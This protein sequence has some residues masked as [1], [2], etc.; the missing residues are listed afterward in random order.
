[1]SRISNGML[2][3]FPVYL[4]Y[5]K[6]LPE[7]APKNISATAIARAL[8]MGEV[9]VRKDLAAISGS[10]KPKIGYI[11]SDLIDEIETNLGYKENRGTVI[12]GAGRLGRALLDY[13]GFKEYGINILAA[14]DNNPDACGETSSGKKIFPLSHLEEFCEEHK[15]QIGV[16]TVPAVNAQNVCD[17]MVECGISAIWNFAPTHLNVRRNI[18]VQNQNIAAS[19]AALSTHL[20]W[21]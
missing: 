18:I 19:I 14:F 15:V 8:C 6:S 7:D 9:N 4:N 10:G 20:K 17:Y 13:V 1:M 2:E 21:K 11:V 5:L 16:I 12:V 3:R